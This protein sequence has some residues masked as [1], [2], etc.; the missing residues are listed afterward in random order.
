MAIS[1]DLPPD[2]ETLLATQY[3]DL[4][5]A[6]KESLAVEAYRSGKLGVNGVRRVLG[7]QTRWQAEQ[8][9]HD[10]HVPINYGLDELES[11]RR[12]LDRLLGETT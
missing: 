6:A 12:T 3:G 1:I 2:I 4:A 10:R 11:D 5:R 9:L 7:F 8:W